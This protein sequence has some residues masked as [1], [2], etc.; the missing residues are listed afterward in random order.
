MF[1]IFPCSVLLPELKAAWNPELGTRV[2]NVASGVEKGTPH[3]QRVGA[4]PCFSFLHP[5]MPQPPKDSVVT[6]GAR[7]WGGR[8]IVE[9]L[10][11]SKR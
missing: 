6:G 2:P 1:P 10:S 11:H 7:A 8:L 9:G 5:L 3:T 4:N